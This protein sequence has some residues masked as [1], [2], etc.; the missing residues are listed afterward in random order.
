VSRADT[1][2][3]ANIQ[4]DITKDIGAYFDHAKAPTANNSKIK[5]VDVHVIIKYWKGWYISMHS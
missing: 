3:E 5:K 2:G 1:C 4:T